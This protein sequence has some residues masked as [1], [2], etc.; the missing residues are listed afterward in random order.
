MENGRF[1]KKIRTYEYMSVYRNRLARQM[2]K[3]VYLPIIC[4]ANKTQFYSLLGECVC[5]TTCK[6]SR[7]LK[8][9]PNYPNYVWEKDLV[10][11]KSKD[12]LP[13]PLRKGKS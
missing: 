12:V 1:R 13:S 11:Q 4:N 7:E 8:H 9:F 2:Y 10:S 6:F 3:D 5:M